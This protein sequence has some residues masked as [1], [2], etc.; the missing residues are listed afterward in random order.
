MK[1]DD[2]M[3]PFNYYLSLET[4]LKASQSKNNRSGQKEEQSNIFYAFGG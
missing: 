1:R 2:D 3:Y 4:T